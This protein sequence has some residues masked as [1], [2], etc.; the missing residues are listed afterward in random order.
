MFR[1]VCILLFSL[2]VCT[3]PIFGTYSRHIRGTVTVEKAQLDLAVRTLFMKGK[4]RQSLVELK[5]FEKKYP[6]SVYRAKVKYYQGMSY[7]HLGEVDPA[8]ESFN[9]VLKKYPNSRY[10]PRCEMKLA[11]VARREAEEAFEAREYVSAVKALQR[12]RAHY[13][14]YRGYRKNRY[15]KNH[16]EAEYYIGLSWLR[17]YEMKH[18]AKTI[19]FADELN[20]ADNSFQA[21]VTDYAEGRYAPA[22]AA[23]Q[24]IIYLYRNPVKDLEFEKRLKEKDKELKETAVSL[25][26][27]EDTLKEQKEQLATDQTALKEEREELGR[28]RQQIEADRKALAEKQQALEKAKQEFAALRA[29]FDKKLKAELEQLAKKQGAIEARFKKVEEAVKKAQED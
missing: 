23:R 8:V 14:N 25:D 26:K 3:P 20:K 5:R 1:N 10:A 2:W 4:Y 29:D 9:R 15:V 11:G 6:Y 24:R 22:A 12:E 21:I 7:L 27:R 17:Q 19:A 28:K 18:A 16:D 13:A